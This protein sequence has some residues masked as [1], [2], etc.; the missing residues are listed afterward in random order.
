M[1][2][3]KQIVENGDAIVASGRDASNRSG[4]GNLLLLTGRLGA[5]SGAEELPQLVEFGDRF[6]ERRQDLFRLIKFHK[7]DLV[8]EAVRLL[9]DAKQ[10][11]D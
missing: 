3:A 10:E 9:T 6:V 11:L 8:C 5:D 2:N 7:F 4:G 1:V